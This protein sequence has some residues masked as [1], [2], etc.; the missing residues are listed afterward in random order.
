[1]LRNTLKW[2][3]ENNVDSIRCDTFESQIIMGHMY[4]YGSDKIGRPVCV[5][6]VHTELDPHTFEQKLFFMVYCMERAIRL[7]DERK[8]VEKMVWL[9]SCQGYNLKYNGDVGFARALSQ[10]LQDH[11]P[12]R[13][14]LL[15]I[16]D[17]PFIFRAMWKLVWPFIDEHTR[18]KIIFI[19]GNE[20]QKGKLISQ[21][22]DLDQ[23]ERTFGGQSTFVF[24]AAAYMATLRTDEAK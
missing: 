8:H 13:L 24:D 23:V 15:L 9:V 12:E 20:T 4:S 17:A 18:Q 11:Y 19:T 6:R 5:L 10:V 1:M 14:G 2:R 16:C 21:Y 3:A 7:M 22:I